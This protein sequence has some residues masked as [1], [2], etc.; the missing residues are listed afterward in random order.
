MWNRAHWLRWACDYRSNRGIMAAI[1][2][3]RCCQGAV[4]WCAA[5][6]VDVPPLAELGW[7]IRSVTEEKVIQV[8][9]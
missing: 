8:N 9:D 4:L 5:R 1:K 3:W 2:L 6:A 7:L